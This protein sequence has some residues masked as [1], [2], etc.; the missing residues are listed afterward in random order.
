MR[1]LAPWNI[2]TQDHCGPHGHEEIALHQEGR[3]QVFSACGWES[4]RAKQRSVAKP[5]SYKSI[6]VCRL[7]KICKLPLQQQ[8]TKT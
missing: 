3:Q 8:K 6:A 1:L 5:M 2:S 7:T 4:D